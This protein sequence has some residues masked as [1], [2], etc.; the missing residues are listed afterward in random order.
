MISRRGF[1]A[2]CIALSAA[3]AIV[4]ADSLM[5]IVPRKTMVLGWNPAG[6][7]EC[8]SLHDDISGFSYRWIT[9]QSVAQF[10]HAGWD[11]HETARSPGGLILARI[12]EVWQ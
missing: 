1:L 11:F 3:P 10:D 2:S 7:A 12:P 9:E 6:L 5:K 4:R 8:A